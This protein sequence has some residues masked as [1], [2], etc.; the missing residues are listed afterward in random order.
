MRTLLFNSI[1]YCSSVGRSPQICT[2]QKKWCQ[3][4]F[5]GI[6][7]PHWVIWIGL[8]PQLVKRNMVTLIWTYPNISGTFKSYP[9]HSNKQ[10]F[11]CNRP[12]L[13]KC[14]VFVHSDNHKCHYRNIACL[15]LDLCLQIKKLQFK[16]WFC[17]VFQ[18]SYCYCVTWKTKYFLV[19]Y[20]FL[21]ML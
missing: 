18:E 5:A 16:R 3:Y 6:H 13:T 15:W 20:W 2:A 11:R 12:S 4:K 10:F 19:Q 7:W 17:T 8:V 1:Q 21:T 14:N 9:S